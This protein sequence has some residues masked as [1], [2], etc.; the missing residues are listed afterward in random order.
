MCGGYGGR[1]GSGAAER[2][3]GQ[4]CGSESEMCSA[5]AGVVATCS[6]VW[7]DASR[8]KDCAEG[9][10]R[11]VRWA[12]ETDIVAGVLRAPVLRGRRSPS[13]A[14]FWDLALK[15]IYASTMARQR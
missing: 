11:M 15:N 7:V 9:V 4:Q 8:L 10:V 6:V 12:S 2:G 5:A 1:G 14:T 13:G 3:G